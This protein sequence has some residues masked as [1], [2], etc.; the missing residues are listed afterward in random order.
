VLVLVMRAFRRGTSGAGKQIAVTD[1]VAVYWHFMDLLWIYLFVL[2][3]VWK[4]V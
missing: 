3:F 1:G 4:S 2:L